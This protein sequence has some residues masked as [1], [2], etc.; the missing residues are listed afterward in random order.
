M[1]PS[2]VKSGDDDSDDDDDDDDIDADDVDQKSYF[3]SGEI[4]RD[5]GIV[6]AA[7]HLPLLQHQSRSLPQR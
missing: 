4:A 3:F 2:D 5:P 7:S 1:H 6:D